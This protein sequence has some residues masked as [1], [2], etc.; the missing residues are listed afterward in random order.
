MVIYLQYTHIR[1][2]YITG[3]LFEGKKN[4]PYQNG[5]GKMGTTDEYRDE[6]FLLQLCLFAL[7]L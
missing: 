1:H 3:F 4:T 7:W 2:D 6:L 5:W